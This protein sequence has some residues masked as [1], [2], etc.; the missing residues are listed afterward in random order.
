MDH[1]CSQEL[2]VCL[3]SAMGYVEL[4]IEFLFLLN[5]LFYKINK[6]KIGTNDFFFFSWCL[7]L[8]LKDEKGDLEGGWGWSICKC[9]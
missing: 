3:D 4:Y 2:L 7:L 5:F 6:S 8:V 1:G 9:I